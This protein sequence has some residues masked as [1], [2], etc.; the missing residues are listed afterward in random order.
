MT[1]LAQKF[2][3]LKNIK[4]ICRCDTCQTIFFQTSYPRLPAVFPHAQVQPAKW[5]LK[6]GR[7][8]IETGKHHL[9]R[10][11]LISETENLREILFDVSSKWIHD[12][13]QHPEWTDRILLA[14]LDSLETVAL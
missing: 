11:W 4:Y 6:A 14:E 3:H 9:V 13:S 7:H 12:L 5:Y 2:R 8:W 10:V 1:S